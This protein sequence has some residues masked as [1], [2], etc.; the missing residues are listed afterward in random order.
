MRENGG[1]I[2][3]VGSSYTYGKYTLPDQLIRFRMECPNVRCQVVNAHSG[4]LYRQLLDGSIDV[5]FVRGN[6]TGSVNHVFLGKTMAYAMTKEPL[7]SLAQLQ[8][9]KLLQQWWAQQF[10]EEPTRGESIG[11]IDVAWQMV[12]KGRGF[13]LCFLPGEYTN[14]YGLC[15]T[16][17]Y[18]ADGSPVSR[19][20][21]LL[22]PQN[23][24]LSENV[25]RFV[26]FILQ[27]RQR[28]DD[29]ISG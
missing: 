23:K 26:D 29:V 22:Y 7:S 4:Q 14:P 13:A 21:W 16:P 8:G 25:E 9:Q 24:H 15:L 19:D 28:A 27:D 12:Q 5:A 1:E 2:V 20:T 10:G 3:T 18:N 17:L 6:Y 11:Y